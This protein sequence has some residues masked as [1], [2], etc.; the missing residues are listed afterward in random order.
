MKEKERIYKK[1]RWGTN[2]GE[3]LCTMEIETSSGVY[4]YVQDRSVDV[5]RG[6]REREGGQ[7][8]VYSRSIP[9]QRFQ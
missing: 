9:S 3:K 4:D 8:G 5:E 6:R 1:L 2:E 7:E